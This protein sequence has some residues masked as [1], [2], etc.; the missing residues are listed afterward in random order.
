MEYLANGEVECVS[1]GRNAALV[2]HGSDDRIPQVAKTKDEL[3][4][5]LKVFAQG[6]YLHRPAMRSQKHAVLGLLA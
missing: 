1:Q 5:L 3:C 6:H 2:Q 4:L